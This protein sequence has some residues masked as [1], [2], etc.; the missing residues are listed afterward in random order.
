MTIN[1]ENLIQLYEVL[2]NRLILQMC[3]NEPSTREILIKEDE[4]TNTLDEIVKDQNVESGIEDSD[5][6]KEEDEKDSVNG[7]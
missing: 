5:V 2:S 1:I 4:T 6:E 7:E 3:K